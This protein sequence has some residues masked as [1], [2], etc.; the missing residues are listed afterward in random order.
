MNPD[1]SSISDINGDSLYLC[2]YKKMEIMIFI[3]HHLQKECPHATN[4][5]TK[6]TTTINEKYAESYFTTIIIMLLSVA[7]DFMESCSPSSWSE[8][9]AAA[10]AST[11]ARGGGNIDGVGSGCDGG[12]AA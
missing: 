12:G 10:A 7:R 4:I 11:A 6:L 8:Y 3:I 2:L 9:P 5:L 1:A